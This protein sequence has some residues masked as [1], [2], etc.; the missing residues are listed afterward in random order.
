MSS[1]IA[2]NSLPGG[3]SNIPLTETFISTA[4]PLSDPTNNGILSLQNAV[5]FDIIK[6]LSEPLSQA[7][8]YT[9]TVSANKTILSTAQT[10]NI[11]INNACD[12]L[13]NP[14]LVLR[15]E[16]RNAATAFA[17]TPVTVS[18]PSSY[19]TQSANFTSQTFPSYSAKVV[20]TI[21]S[22]GNTLAGNFASS[23]MGYNLVLN[24]GNAAE[25]NNA[26]QGSLASENLTTASLKPTFGF[27]SEN[28]KISNP[29]N[30]G[31]VYAGTTATVNCISKT[32]DQYVITSSPSYIHAS[33][34]YQINLSSSME[35][36][37]E[38]TYKIQYSASGS[39][40]STNY[41]GGPDEIVNLVLTSTD[42]NNNFALTSNAI[43]TGLTTSISAD[44]LFPNSQLV[45]I[46][47]GDTA[48]AGPGGLTT[49][50]VILNAGLTYNLSVQTTGL[51]TTTL[52][53][54]YQLQSS[55]AS[56]FSLNNANLTPNVAYM[57]EFYAGGNS[58]AVHSIQVN[59][60]TVAIGKPYDGVSAS[61]DNAISLG[62]ESE[63]LSSAILTN[64]EGAANGNIAVWVD[65]VNA[66]TLDTTLTGSGFSGVT[67]KVY[68][69]NTE[70]IND[71]LTTAQQNAMDG[72][73]FI[74]ANLSYT[75]TPYVCMGSNNSS[76]IQS[77]SSASMYYLGGK[78]ASASVIQSNFSNFVDSNSNLST[79]K[80]NSIEVYSV[81]IQPDLFANGSNM[82][83]ATDANQQFPLISHNT[84]LN[85]VVGG[86]NPILFDNL[87]LSSAGLNAREFRVQYSNK[88]ISQLSGY[89]TTMLSTSGF[90]LALQSAGGVLSTINP[91]KQANKNI[92]LEYECNSQNSL[93][94]YFK[95][96][97][98]GSSAQ[99]MN[100]ML[101]LPGMNMVTSQKPFASLTV[102]D[103]LPS[104]FPCD[105]SSVALLSGVGL[106]N[107]LANFDL[108]STK[109]SVKPT[110]VPTF[111]SGWNVQAGFLYAIPQT[112]LACVLMGMGNLQVVV[113][114]VWVSVFT[115]SIVN[116]GVPTYFYYPVF[117]NNATGSNSPIAPPMLQLFVG[118]NDMFSMKGE[119]QYSGDG[120]NWA[121]YPGTVSFN[122]DPNF[123]TVTYPSMANFGSS[124][125]MT[126]NFMIDWQAAS[127]VTTMSSAAYFSSLSLDGLGTV[128]PVTSNQEIVVSRQTLTPAQLQAFSSA[129]LLSSAQ[130]T[131]DAL[132][133]GPS[134][135]SVSTANNLQG[136]LYRPKAV[137]S[138][139]SVSGGSG[140]T[141]APGKINITD[142]GVEKGGVVN[143]TL[144]NGSLSFTLV[145]NGSGYTNP[146]IVVPAPAVTSAQIAI[147]NW[148]VGALTS[149]MF[150]VA[151]GGSGQKTV[152]LTVTRAGG[153]TAS[154]AT[155]ASITATIVNGV[156]TRVNVVNGGNYAVKPSVT[157]G[158]IVPDTAIVNANLINSAAGLGVAAGNNYCVAIYGN[159]PTTTPELPPSNLLYSY[160]INAYTFQNVA[161]VA[162]A[163][164]IVRVIEKATNANG[165][166]VSV[167]GGAY[168]ALTFVKNNALSMGPNSGINISGINS[169]AMAMSDKFV[170]NVLNDAVSVQLYPGSS[171]SYNTG[172]P[173]LPDADGYVQLPTGRLVGPTSLKSQVTVP[174]VGGT[175]TQNAQSVIF[176][177]ARNILLNDALL[178]NVQGAATNYPIAGFSSA[179]TTT[180][181]SGLTP[182]SNYNAGGAFYNYDPVVTI[183]VPAAP[184][185][186]TLSSLATSQSS[187]NISDASKLRNIL[188]GMTVSGTGV[189]NGTVV[190][191]VKGSVVT[192]NNAITLTT[193]QLASLS[194]T[195]VGT[196]YTP[197]SN[198]GVNIPAPFSAAGDLTMACTSTSIGGFSLTTVG[199]VSV[200]TSAAITTSGFN[201]GRGYTAALT[202]VNFPVPDVSGS[203]SS[204]NTARIQ[205]TCGLSGTV[206]AASLER[207][208]AGYANMPVNC[209]AQSTQN[210][211]SVANVNFTT[212]TPTVYAA[213]PSVSLSSSQ[214]GVPIFNLSGA[215][216]Q[217][218]TQLNMGKG[219]FSPTSSIFTTVVII[220][221]PARVQSKFNIGINPIGKVVNT[222]SSINNNTVSYSTTQ[223]NLMTNLTNGMLSSAQIADNTN[224]VF[225][226]NGYSYANVAVDFSDKKLAIHNGVA[227][228]GWNIFKTP[229]GQDVSVP[230]TSANL[231]TYYSTWN[232]ATP[233]MDG[234]YMWITDP[235]DDPAV[236]YVK[237]VKGSIGLCL[238]A[239]GKG[240]EMNQLDFK[241][242]SGSMTAPVCTATGGGLGGALNSITP[243]ITSATNYY[244]LSD[245]ITITPIASPAASPAIINLAFQNGI[246]VTASISSTRGAGFGENLETFI[247]DIPHN[248]LDYVQ[249][250]G[251]AIINSSTGAIMGVN[252]TNRGSGYLQSSY[253]LTI[254]YG[255]TP[256]R[257]SASVVL[258]PAK[259]N[260]VSYSIVR[261]RGNFTFRATPN[262]T[263]F[264]TCPQPPLALTYGNVLNVNSLKDANNASKYS[265][266]GLGLVITASPSFMAGKSG[267][268]N[269]LL[270]VNADKYELNVNTN[271]PNTVLQNYLTIP[272]LGNTAKRTVSIN[273]ETGVIK[274]NGS[275]TDFAV[276]N[277]LP[278][279][280]FVFSSVYN[281]SYPN[282]VFSLGN[283][284]N[285][286]NVFYSSS[287][288][289]PNSLSYSS[290]N[291][292]GNATNSSTNK[293]KN[294]GSA[295]DTG[296]IYPGFSI[297]STS[298]PQYSTTYF[299][300]VRPQV[301]FTLPNQA[302]SS[303]PYALSNPKTYYLDATRASQALN[304][305][306][307]G[308]SATLAAIYNPQNMNINTIA[309]NTSV[310]YNPVN[311]LPNANSLSVKLNDMVNGLIEQLSF[312]NNGNNTLLL[313]TDLSANIVRGTSNSIVGSISYD[314][315]SRSYKIAYTQN[316]DADA[317]VTGSF[318]I[319]PATANNIFINFT[320]SYMSVS[321]TGYTL[322]LTVNQQSNLYLYGSAFQVY[323]KTVAQ[324][325]YGNASPSKL[326]SGQDLVSNSHVN[327]NNYV[328]QVKTIATT[329]VNKPSAALNAYSTASLV[330]GSSTI[331]DAN[332]NIYTYQGPLTTSI[333][334]ASYANGLTLSTASLYN[335]GGFVFK[336]A[337]IATLTTPNKAGAISAL[338]SSIIIDANNNTYEFKDYMNGAQFNVITR[339]ALVAD[340]M[341]GAAYEHK[342]LKFG[343]NVVNING[344]STTINL[345][346]TM[347]LVQNN[348]SSV[349]SQLYVPILP[350]NLADY[351]NVVDGKYPVMSFKEQIS[352]GFSAL[353]LTA[354]NVPKL[355]NNNQSDVLN[356]VALPI[357]I[358]CTSLPSTRLLVD[359]LQATYP[360]EYQNVLF[361]NQPDTFATYSP[362]GEQMTR[363]RANG[364][365]I[366]PAVKIA[367]ASLSGYTNNT[368]Y[369]PNTAGYFTTGVSF[370]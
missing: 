108:N 26:F 239:G 17:T 49:A 104:A 318:S 251:T 14:T 145:N 323:N 4:Y 240:F 249:A 311:V 80:D 262:G 117:Y 184:T 308:T 92:S 131:I 40:S 213:T 24:G 197:G 187:L 157:V 46:A 64:V 25:L 280:Y 12:V 191:S 107:T 119:L 9:P 284:S 367:N 250:A 59:N 143:A 91:A 142:S 179:L 135:A 352:K 129:Q 347:S 22:G 74:P 320:N 267:V 263:T 173:A 51:S 220:S 146:Q 177:Q 305:S 153:D 329:T 338:T 198:Y 214:I 360:R 87:T 246:M 193:A 144:S 275:V 225:S 41:T 328:Y 70:I 98:S 361:I 243:T 245:T 271:Y 234:F 2:T 293:F 102:S 211:A 342:D 128:N 358:T 163:N 38:G 67:K 105:G 114:A 279:S 315:L 357:S 266:V 45:T 21:T 195:N 247:Y 212:I 295:G 282:A 298:T 100:L 160:S 230:I 53:G 137:Y 35:N 76:A 103:L 310:T 176:G 364:E 134:V 277:F 322:P 18:T 47:N 205:I 189:S 192:L 148:A 111:P 37:V 85:G 288:D 106:V 348:N 118:Y 185:S 90:A 159:A 337:T 344:T 223:T 16:Y 63:Y 365:A 237:I 52:P 333:A 161:I 252:L 190:S 125:I 130:L 219:Y 58:S 65:P 202:S 62:G 199:L 20:L 259:Q 281:A 341:F 140:Y 330:Q 228:N 97:G 208:G 139:T 34:N 316:P 362:L 42:V 206:S 346:N 96:N 287:L 36:M 180:A 10:D 242:P 56:L 154:P 99:Q 209:T 61:I 256:V 32:G 158:A 29:A 60:G 317:Y 335:V 222:L 152:A 334:A 186:V 66:R 303:Y 171:N 94:S 290:T 201:L 55:D 260:F 181:I 138:L 174:T 166:D 268:V 307:G 231:Q 235:N 270:D 332:S 188:Q 331:T 339:S 224:F 314:T 368:P 39:G 366:V 325:G 351:N 132:F 210:F 7:P 72:S 116:A 244:T 71:G 253:P 170:F 261:T 175:T 156:V 257:A 5:E 123:S 155:D 126:V 13:N 23:N 151:I 309:T 285:E 182:S 86:A 241:Q 164:N 324:L 183:D 28:N 120:T 30:F 349:V 297:V 27:N 165:D 89:S 121:L 265:G 321:S 327:V 289:N 15:S 172:L 200:M 115:I 150:S 264:Y 124:A 43:Q 133:S 141:V 167:T 78:N 77:T 110:N 296:I 343:S 1:A 274:I 54:G 370:N 276:T 93:V 248:S 44:S 218:S 8:D 363:L 207:A 291:G 336:P 196:G 169:G 355:W 11:Q 356:D 229:S 83:D 31:S 73:R 217:N 301:Y 302:I 215:N 162:N 278:S 221:A 286:S 6:S 273:T 369:D 69:N 304:I 236:V 194:I 50:S 299:Q 312:N 84:D 33:K 350:I 3:S 82:V 272:G 88:T 232:S 136:I 112:S 292:T 109:L 255:G 147:N 313:K 57:K 216:P 294:A 340:L 345:S 238:V 258:T 48:G 204:P 300:I 75:I 113:P 226:G 168:A 359:S 122:V 254:A 319:S 81:K 127:N 95:Q 178:T 233:G 227:N 149:A 283:F 353:G 269:C 101:G 354:N 203:S 79:L 68:Y 326:V 19:P 306:Y